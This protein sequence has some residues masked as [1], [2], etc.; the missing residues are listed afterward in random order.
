MIL[1]LLLSES[2]T[3]FE[4][5]ESALPC[6]TE[7][8]F[9][10]SAGIVGREKAVSSEACSFWASEEIDFGG[11]CSLIGVAVASSEFTGANFNVFGP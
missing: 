9:E 7:G 5:W 3:V 1:R 11:K 10:V 4:S 6:S 2:F 8:S